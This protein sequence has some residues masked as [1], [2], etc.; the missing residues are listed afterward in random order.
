[1]RKYSTDC[2]IL[3]IICYHISNLNGRQYVCICVETGTKVFGVLCEA[4]SRIDDCKEDNGD[5]AEQH[6]I[7]R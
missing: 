7:G 1:M 4:L 5:P 2:I 6:E 3:I